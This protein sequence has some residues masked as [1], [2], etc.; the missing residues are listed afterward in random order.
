M[1][2][3]LLILLFS[4]I[5]FSSVVSADTYLFGYTPGGALGG[6]IRFDLKPGVVLDLA[7][8]GG[9][10][11]SGS[12]YSLYA[13]IFCGYWGLGITAKKATVNSNLAFDITPQFALEQPI[14]DKVFIG[15]LVALCN[16]D[17]TTG[18][19]PSFTLF[20]TIVPY[21]VLAF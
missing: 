3:V 12:T 9:S 17:T 13:D 20:P 19:D 7:A 2:K 18:A 14:N 10:G 8:S 11:S 16:F 21:F 1:K 15:V 6:G 4:F 5:L